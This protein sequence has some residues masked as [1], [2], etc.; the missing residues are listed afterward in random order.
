MRKCRF[1][2]LKKKFDETSLPVKF[3][4]G[5]GFYIE[6]HR[7]IFIVIA[8]GEIL[9]LIQIR[10]LFMSTCPKSLY[11]CQSFLLFISAGEDFGSWASVQISKVWRRQ[12]REH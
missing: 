12:S 10:A 11:M 2:H 7:E 6:E 3:R 9:A 5:Q 4:N 1:I 8:I